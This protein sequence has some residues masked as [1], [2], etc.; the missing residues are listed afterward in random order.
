MS[1]ASAS[2]SP[3]RSNFSK[4]TSTPAAASRL[5][6]RVFGPEAA[7]SPLLTPSNLPPSDQPPIRSGSAEIYRRAAFTDP[8]DV[9]G[10]ASNP[11][12]IT[13]ALHSDT[14]SSCPTPPT[15]GP[16]LSPS[17]SMSRLE[18]QRWSVLPPI[19]PVRGKVTINPKIRRSPPNAKI[20]T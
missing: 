11:A 18:S 9:T 1:S 10:S 5:C 15:S 3:V 8:Q 7:L 12:L 14:W 16:K 6:G 19:S 20:Y 17:A 4:S 2:S 13:S